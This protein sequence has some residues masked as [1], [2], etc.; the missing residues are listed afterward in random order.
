V[1]PARA[2]RP[3]HAWSRHVTPR[4]ARSTH[5]AKANPY[6]AAADGSAWTSPFIHASKNQV[7]HF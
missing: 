4:Y 6:D 7:G 1:N 3:V 5:V 2:P